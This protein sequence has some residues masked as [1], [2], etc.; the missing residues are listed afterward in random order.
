[1]DPNVKEIFVNRILLKFLQHG[2][3]EHGRRMLGK[4]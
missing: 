4:E 2:G 3:S 1:M